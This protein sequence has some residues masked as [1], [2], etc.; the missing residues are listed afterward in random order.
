MAK[1]KIPIDAGAEADP[2]NYVVARLALWAGDADEA[3]MRLSVYKGGAITRGW[4]HLINKSAVR[5][6]R[7]KRRQSEYKAIYSAA[8][9]PYSQTTEHILRSTGSHL[10]AVIWVENERDYELRIYLLDLAWEGEFYRIAEVSAQT[11]GVMA[12]KPGLVPS[13]GQ[14][15][16]D[17]QGN[18]ASLG[19]EWAIQ[20]TM[21]L[22][23]AVGDFG[24][25]TVR[26]TWTGAP[27][28]S[29]LSEIIHPFQDL[30]DRLD[31][32]PPAQSSRP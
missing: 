6:R 2:T 7:L 20:G 5:T 15:L 16:G 22:Q 11:L 4:S 24:T 12:T 23:V 10:G 25:A 26:G 13:Y 8:G 31:P 27:L 21:L 18:Q 19:L 17:G 14:K 3:A 28:P 1:N 9:M 30:L 32:S 29:Q